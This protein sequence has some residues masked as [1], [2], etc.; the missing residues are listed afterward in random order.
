M[1][2]GAKPIDRDPL[3]LGRPGRDAARAV[4]L[5]C[6]QGMPLTVNARAT[7]HL[8]ALPHSY[9]GKGHGRRRASIAGAADA[10]R[11]GARA[12]CAPAAPWSSAM[13]RRGLV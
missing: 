7:G 2:A 5:R 3:G 6:G 8:P 11:Q 4:L 13:R 10:W 9:E 1:R 12:F